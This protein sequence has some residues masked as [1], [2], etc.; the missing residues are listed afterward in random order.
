MSPVRRPEVP[1]ALSSLRKAATLPRITAIAGTPWSRTAE[2]L[3]NL[4]MLSSHGATSS[5]HTNCVFY[6]FKREDATATCELRPSASGSGYDLVIMETG[7]PVVTEQYEFA[8]DAHKRWLEVQQRFK[9]EGWW[10]P[11]SA[12]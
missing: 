10:G 3:G 11:T 9:T 8:A 7:K 12:Q 5:G 1:R 2:Y 4:V 6:F